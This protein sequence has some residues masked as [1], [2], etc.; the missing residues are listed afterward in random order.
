[1]ATPQEIKLQKENNKLQKEYNEILKDRIGISAK[2]KADGDDFAN[3]LQSASK[4]IKEQT[5]QRRELLSISNRLTKTS[6]DEFALLG[7]ELRAK[8]AGL[9][10][11]KNKYLYKKIFLT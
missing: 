4:I 2:E 1:M 5:V 9:N 8:N 6:A 3:A 11:G 10:I 7:K